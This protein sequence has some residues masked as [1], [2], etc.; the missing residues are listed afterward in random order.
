MSIEDGE[1]M[2]PRKII[3]GHQEIA[4]TPVGERREVSTEVC[5]YWTVYQIIL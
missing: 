5:V 3:S 1:L 2:V 4:K